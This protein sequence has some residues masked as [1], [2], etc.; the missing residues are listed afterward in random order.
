VLYGNNDF[1]FED[2]TPYSTNTPFFIGSGDLNSDGSTDLYGLNGFA[3][4]QQLGVFYGNSSRTFSSYFTTLSR[5]YP[6]GASSDAVN[7]MS[8]FT[9]ADFNGDGR[10][11]LAAMGWSA[12]YA[13][14]Y[15]EVFLAGSSPGQFTMQPVQLPTT[16]N[17]DSAPIAGLFGD[18]LLTPDLVLNRSPNYG[19]PPQNTP[20]YLVAEVNQ[21]SR[22]YFG[23]CYYPRS[24]EGFNVCAPGLVNGSTATFNASANSYGQ[25]RKIELWVDGRKLSEQY[26]TWDK[27]AYFAFSATFA[28]GAH[29]ATLFAADVDNRLQRSDFTFTVVP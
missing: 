19:S 5:S 18:S 27:H 20:S 23:P 21:A 9:L 15:M 12:D 7:D 25:I 11:D 1:T 17:E 29:Q 13:T 6:L 4:V 2:T 26:H 22:G 28:A 16:Y 3:G 14:A 10:M 24:G 8:Q